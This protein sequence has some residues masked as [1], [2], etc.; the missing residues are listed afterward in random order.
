MNIEQR[1]TTSELVEELRS[2]M[3][4]TNGWIPALCGAGG[5]AGLL[6]DAGLAEV[7]NALQEFAAAAVPAAVARQLEHAAASVASALAGDDSTYGHLGM[8][9]AYVLQ[10]RRATS[11][12]TL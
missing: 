9:Y 10:A 3:D 6:K 5:P 1:L 8:A 12:I 4:A 11:E 7:V 2:S